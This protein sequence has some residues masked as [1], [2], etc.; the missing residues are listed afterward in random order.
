[1][2][3]GKQWNGV[4]SYATY[5]WLAI[6][7]NIPAQV[8][9]SVLSPSQYC[10]VCVLA[11]ISLSSALHD[12]THLKIHARE[13][14]ENIVTEVSICDI[15]FCMGQ[16]YVGHVL[17]RT[18]AREISSSY[19]MIVQCVCAVCVSYVFYAMCSDTRPYQ[20]DHVEAISKKQR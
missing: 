5:D 1:M 10:L 8:P 12:L 20:I 7:L 19:S 6:K 9:L 2:R 17:F 3:K 18:S 16:G 14:D 15:A 13:R 11:S 4:S